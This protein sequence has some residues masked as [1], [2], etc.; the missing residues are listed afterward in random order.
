MAYTLTY[1][2]GIITVADGTLNTTGTSISIPGR[3]YVGYGSPVDQ[4]MVSMLENFA[5]S[6]TGPTSPL[7]G[8][9]WYD[10]ANEVVKYNTGTKTSPSWATVVSLGSSP[11]FG[12]VT[13]TGNVNTVNVNATGDISTFNL[14]ALND[15]TTI[16]VTASGNVS[17][18]NIVSNGFFVHSTANGVA[19]SGT[20]QGSATLLAAEF[21]VITSVPV[22]SGVRLPVTTGGLRLTVVNN[23]AIA[24]N[25]YPNTSAS[26][27]SGTVNTA[28]SL[29][30]GSRLDY[31]S[32]S[33]T[34]WYTLNATYS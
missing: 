1:S 26:I 2:G 12:N 27:N 14:F 18:T 22:N 20:N 33:A 11:T 9:F 30:A 16:D 15:V 25:I 6:S 31:V 24:V 7:K 13:V 10:V 21:N 28:Y 5:S 32:V 23:G 34:Q 17:G 3:N 19:A 8:Q 4:N 29:A